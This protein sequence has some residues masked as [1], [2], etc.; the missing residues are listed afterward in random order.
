MYISYLLAGDVKSY[1]YIKSINILL[2]LIASVCKFIVY[3]HHVVY[4]SYCLKCIVLYKVIVN[5]EAII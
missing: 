1:K 5:L 2:L 3:P 4:D